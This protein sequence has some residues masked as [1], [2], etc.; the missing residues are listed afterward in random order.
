MLFYDFMPSGTHAYLLDTCRVNSA[1]VLALNKGK[2]PRKQD[3][4]EHGI[5][6]V[7]Q[8]VRPFVEMRSRLGLS[9][10]VI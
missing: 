9:N 8:L 1:A 6:L 5:S 4:F 7:L 2:D 3:A 10:A